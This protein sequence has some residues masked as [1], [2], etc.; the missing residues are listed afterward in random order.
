[1]AWIERKYASILG[2]TPG[3]FLIVVVLQLSNYFNM[4]GVWNKVLRCATDGTQLRNSCKVNR[5]HHWPDLGTANLAILLL[6]LVLSTVLPSI[7]VV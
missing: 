2:V 4:I 1:M 3:K 7:A 6:A 5:L